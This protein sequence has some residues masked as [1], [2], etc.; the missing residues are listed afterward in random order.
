MDL[1]CFMLIYLIGLYLINTDYYYI[2]MFYLFFA[3]IQA[4]LCI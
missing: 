1:H 2:I 4:Y 3:N